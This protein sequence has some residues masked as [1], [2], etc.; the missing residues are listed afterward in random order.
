MLYEVITGLAWGTVLGA[1]L[2]LLVQLPGLRKLSGLRYSFGL[3]LKDPAV[4]KVG[5]LMLP[6]LFGAAVVQLNFLV[7]I[8]SYNVCY[9]KLLRAF[10]RKW[11]SDITSC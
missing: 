3:G 9:T 6:R 1:G 10:A 11:L 7:R 2:H 5:R 4:R 8:T